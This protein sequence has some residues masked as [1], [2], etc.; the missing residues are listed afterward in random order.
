[1]LPWQLSNWVYR[2]VFIC[3]KYNPF[4]VMEYWLATR[5]DAELALTRLSVVT[6]TSAFLPVLFLIRSMFR[7]RGHF[8]D[9]H[10]RPLTSLR[11]A[12]V[13][14]MGDRPLAWWAVRRVMEYSGRMNIWLAGGFG[15]LYACYIILGN[16]WPA[17]MGRMVFEIFE[18]LGGVP[19]LST[20]LVILAA[21]PAAFQYGL[22]DPSIQDRCRRLELLLLTELDGADYWGAA[23]A[24]AWKRGRAYFMVAIILWLAMAWSG[25]AT[26]AQVAMAALAAFLLWAFAFVVGFRAFSRGVHSNGLGTML[27]IGLP[28]LA[29]LLVALNL[30]ELASLL[31]PGSLY[32]ALTREPSMA[33][34]PGPMITLVAIVAIARWSRRDCVRD[35]RAWFDVHQGRKVMS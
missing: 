27:T 35:L 1:M 12:E 14:R 30:P 8:Q 33:W 18:R 3:S 20:G 32:V 31:P 21:V 13:S 24:A 17:W 16:A 26:S 10:Y 28:T 34:L 29:G 23:R 5:R 25:R 22:W 7:L 6:L 4:G 15:C 9:R 2:L 19:A 11:K